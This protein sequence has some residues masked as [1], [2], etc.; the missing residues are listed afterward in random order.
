[1]KFVI[2]EELGAMS[3]P[4][5]SIRNVAELP[6]SI[7]TACYLALALPSPTAV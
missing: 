1:M 2:I 3:Y 7:F 5:Y 4:E 6:V